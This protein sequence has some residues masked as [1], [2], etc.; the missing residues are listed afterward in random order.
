[1]PSQILLS[2]KAQKGFLPFPL[3]DMDFSIHEGSLLPFNVF[4]QKS[5]LKREKIPHIQKWNSLFSERD[6]LY[7]GWVNSEQRLVAQPESV[8]GLLFA[9]VK[10]RF[11][12]CAPSQQQTANQKQVVMARFRPPTTT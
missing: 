8:Y 10:A 1:M 4:C 6:T 3:I 12:A 9:A 2:Q 5:I 11:W 7:H